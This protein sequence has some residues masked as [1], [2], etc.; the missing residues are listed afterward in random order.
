MRLAPTPTRRLTAAA[1]L[2][3]VIVGVA[4]A[5]AA[6]GAALDVPAV[7]HGDPAPPAPAPGAIRVAT[8]NVLNLFDPADD[9]ALGGRWDDLPNATDEQRCRNIAAMIRRIDA[10]VIALQEV[11]SLDCVRWFRDTFLA[12]MGYD[13]IAS[14]DVDYYRGVECSVLSRFPIEEVTVWPNQSLEDVDRDGA[15]FTPLPEDRDAPATYQ[16]SPMRVDVRVSDDYALT[17]FVLHHKSGRSFG[18]MR[19]MEALRTVEKLAAIADAEPDRNVIVLGDFNA[20]PWDRSL[21]LY[22]EA[23]FVDSLAHRA[24][25]RADGADP[26]EARRYKTHDSG[27]VIDYVLMNAAA[28]DEFV[29]GSAHVVGKP[30]DPGYDWRNDPHPAWFASDHHPVVVDLRPTDAR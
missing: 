4:A 19:E 29:V 28:Y 13:H 22:L 26:T 11:E 10:D 18:W 14:E 30:Y 6:G 7:R 9:P 3:G 23:G 5:A 24:M 27:R 15:G 2:A 17:L 16:R 20:A 1:L 25:P 21:R 12:D 8:Y